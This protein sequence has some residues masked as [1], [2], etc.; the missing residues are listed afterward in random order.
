MVIKNFDVIMNGDTNVVILDAET[1]EFLY[2]DEWTAEDL[3]MWANIAA[4]KGMSFTEWM[5]HVIQ[6]NIEML[7][8]NNF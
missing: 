5:A 7:N 2:E 1:R 3:D 4:E 8:E 6:D